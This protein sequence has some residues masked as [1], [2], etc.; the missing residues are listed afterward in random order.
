[1]AIIAPSCAWVSSA[2]LAEMAGL[3]PSLGMVPRTDMCER[4]I[5]SEQV[6]EEVIKERHMYARESEHRKHRYCCK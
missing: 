4:D 3:P 5:V 2:Q 6:R 1:M